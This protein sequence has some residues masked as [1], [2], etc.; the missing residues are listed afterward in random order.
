VHNNRLA[1]LD[2]LCLLSRKK[3]GNPTRLADLSHLNELLGY[4]KE[5]H[6]QCIADYLHASQSADT[7]ELSA[8]AQPVRAASV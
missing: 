6:S 5:G 7:A 3:V 8:L 4:D 2:P 1:L